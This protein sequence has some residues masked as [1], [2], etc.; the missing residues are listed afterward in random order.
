MDDVTSARM[1]ITPGVP[2]CLFMTCGVSQPMELP[3]ALERDDF[4]HRRK[5][6]LLA[7][8]NRAKPLNF[9]HLRRRHRR[10]G[11]PLLDQRTS[12]GNLRLPKFRLGEGV[13]CPGHV[14]I[15]QGHAPGAPLSL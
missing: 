5:S 6:C 11:E 14:S 3:D 9:N 12:A 15:G 7:S 1:K 8:S 13:A 10:H 2:G 4:D